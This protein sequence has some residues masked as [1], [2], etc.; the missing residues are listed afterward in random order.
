MHRGVGV[1][2]CLLLATACT[3]GGPAKSDPASVSAAGNDGLSTEQLRAAVAATT[4]F[5]TAQVAVERSLG[6]KTVSSDQ[7]AYSI[8]KQQALTRRDD[9]LNQ[10]GDEWVYVVDHGAMYV[11][12]RPAGPVSRC[13]LQTATGPVHV[14]GLPVAPRF[15][16]AV[17]ALWN[18]SDLGGGSSPTEATATLP[19]VLAA[20][21]VAPSLPTQLTT[22]QFSQPVAVRLT[23][24]A[25][26]LVGMQITGTDVL[27][28]LS[29]AN[30]SL[31]SKSVVGLSSSAAAVT[32]SGFGDPVH[33]ELPDS[34]PVV[35]SKDAHARAKC[36]S[37]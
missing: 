28:A 11:G 1:A 31:S 30:V 15:P 34:A 33:T 4:R 16:E 26:R 21:V 18:L 29:A 20:G 14:A 6:D 27:D 17:R 10:T 5:D 3:G 7:S 22:D 24:D 36:Q 25:G 35:S 12:T 2:A 9:L 13:W 19:L 37:S 23:V 8:K 32:Y